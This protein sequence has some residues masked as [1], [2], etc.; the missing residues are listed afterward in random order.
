[1]TVLTSIA[2]EGGA[3]PWLDIVG[4]VLIGALCLLGFVRGL[5]W[6]AVR[7]LGIAASVGAARA[8]APTLAPKLLDVFPEMN[9]RLGLGFVWFGIFVLG[10]VLVS[11][12]GLLGKKSLEVMQLGF[13]DR[14][15]GAL[16]GLLT[17]VLLHSALLVALMH[18][19]SEDWTQ[20][21]M[22]NT[23]SR[24]LF[25]SLARKVPLVVDRETANRLSPW[26]L[27]SES[28]VHAAEK[29]SADSG[30]KVR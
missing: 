23:T 9:E 1:M 27:P 10:L 12:V 5:W 30:P 14:M 29:K 4:L 21:A 19:G 25:D 28:E 3:L 8:L 17:A 13:A 2:G 24:V 15:G 11:L 6:Q 7:L 18:F 20:S 22:R 26:L 16:A